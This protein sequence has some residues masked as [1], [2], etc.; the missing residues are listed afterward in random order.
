MM[1]VFITLDG[2]EHSSLPHCTSTSINYNIKQR[3]LFSWSLSFLLALEP[4]IQRHSGFPKYHHTAEK[5]ISVFN[6]LSPCDLATVSDSGCM[7][8]YI[9]GG[10]VYTTVEAFCMYII[11]N[12]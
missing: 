7:C 1:E 10:S 2:L 3:K 8:M 9:S 6:V 11:D 4:L 12:F 5:T